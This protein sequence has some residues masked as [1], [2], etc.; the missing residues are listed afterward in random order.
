MPNNLDKKNI[1]PPY[2]IDNM[3]F[4][5]PSFKTTHNTDYTTSPRNK[6]SKVKSKINNSKMTVS[7]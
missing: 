6:Y 3:L 4:K 1:Y 5:N 7:K 2:Q